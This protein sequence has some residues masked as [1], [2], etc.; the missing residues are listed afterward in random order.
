MAA[1]IEL[2]KF[3]LENKAQTRA[4]DIVSFVFIVAVNKNSCLA[5]SK[6]NENHW[7]KRKLFN[8]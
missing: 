6:L 3:Y 7:F 5:K 1:V 2:N 4:E 8:I